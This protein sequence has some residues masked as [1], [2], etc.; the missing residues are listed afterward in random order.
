MYDKLSAYKLSKGKQYKSDYGAI[1]TWVVGS[2]KE[3][4][5]KKSKLD[6]RGKAGQIMDAHAELTKIQ[7]QRYGNDNS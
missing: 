7:Q 6:E 3:E 5:N 1:L 2:L 4:Q